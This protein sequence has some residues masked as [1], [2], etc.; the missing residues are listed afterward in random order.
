MDVGFTAQMEE[1]LDKVA[2]GG[3]D[4]V[5]LLRDFS[6]DFDPTLAA[7]AKAMNQ[8]KTGVSTDVACPRCGKP[9]VVKFGK[10]GEF[11]ACSGYPECRFTSNYTRD[12]KGQ[13]HI[14]ERVKPE[15]EK[16]GVCPECGSDL[17]IK[18][19]RAGS[20][21]IAC[22]PMTDSTGMATVSEARPKPDRS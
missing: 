15:L 12:E 6:R 20:R 10:T 8:V 5:A 7:A 1:R 17:V 18:M 16:V 22:T 21:F 11:L 19:S 3:Q 9:L 13:I 4:W 14:Q 2:E